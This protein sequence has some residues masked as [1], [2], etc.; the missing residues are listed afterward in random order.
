[1]VAR[2][3]ILCKQAGEVRGIREGAELVRRMLVMTDADRLTIPCAKP[4]VAVNELLRSGDTIGSGVVV[5]ESGQVVALEGGNV[6][7]RIGRPY[8]VSPGAVLQIDRS[9]LVQRGDNLA[10]LV[11]ERAK[12]GDIIQG[13][14]RI[15]ELLEGR[16]PKEMC[17]LA[18]KA[19]RVQ[20]VYDSDDNAEVK[21]IEEDGNV[22][23]YP[24]N[25]GQSLIVSDGQVVNAAEAL[26]DGPAN[27]HDILDIFFRLHRET[28]GVRE[29]ALLSLQ[30]VQEFLVNEVQSVYQSQ[31]VDISDKHIEVV[32][33]QMTSKVRIDDGGD[34][35]RLP[36]ELVDLHQVEQINEAM[37]ITGSVP[38]E[39]TPILM[40]ITKASLNTDSFISAASFQET[41]RVLTEAAI[42][43]KSDWLRGLKEN[44]IIGRLIPAGT[45]FNAYDNI[46]NDMESVYDSAIAYEEDDDNVVIDDNIARSLPTYPIP[47][48]PSSD[49]GDELVDDDA[50]YED[51]YEDEFEDD[52]EDDFE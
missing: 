18:Q 12:T 23:E 6:T 37:E 4:A 43:G 35:T 16:K 20:V 46:S 14:P 26:T 33:K 50:E 42:E 30:Q 40:G 15:E 34:T 51:E 3:E 48:P 21:I 39:Y 11:F 19:G 7:I 49:Y 52:D 25:A 45:G 31:G 27:P 5:P 29:A 13:L 32:V 38:A 41:T 36:G 47:T 44:V 8:L 10:L 1:V 17:V 2:T 28:K 22:S 24:L 9:D